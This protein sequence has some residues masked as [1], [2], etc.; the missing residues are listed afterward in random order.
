MSLKQV[1]EGQANKEHSKRCRIS[2][3]MGARG[4]A[5]IGMPL[6]ATASPMISPNRSAIR[7]GF[8]LGMTMV[9]EGL[10]W[11]NPDAKSA[12]TSSKEA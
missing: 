8:S 1:E 3:D 5:G 6:M 9:V 11:E 2:S 4:V 7:R 10:E 12:K